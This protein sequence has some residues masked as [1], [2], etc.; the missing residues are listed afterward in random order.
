MNRLYYEKDELHLEEEVPQSA[1]QVQ[2]ELFDQYWV[3]IEYYEK[4]NEVFHK[5]TK[6]CCVDIESQSTAK[7]TLAR[8]KR[9]ISTHYYDGEFTI[10]NMCKL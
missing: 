9:Y 2:L 4:C 1:Q 7:D 10:K 3:L 6:E 8:I 5:K